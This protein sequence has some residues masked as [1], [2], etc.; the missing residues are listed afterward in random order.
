MI[1]LLADDDPD[2]WEIFQEGL[3]K[4]VPSHILHWVKHGDRVLQGVKEIMPDILFLD[5]NLPG[6]DGIECLRIIKKGTNASKSLNS[7]LYDIERPRP[8]KG[9]SCFRGFEIFVKTRQL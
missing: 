2:D 3:M 1:I 9:M 5:L 6:S 7:Y 8:R 4:I